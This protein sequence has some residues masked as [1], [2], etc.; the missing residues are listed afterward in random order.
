MTTSLRRAL[1][2]NTNRRESLD[3]AENESSDLAPRSSRV[4]RKG[5]VKRLLSVFGGF[6]RGA[7]DQSQQIQQSD[8]LILKKSGL[9]EL[10]SPVDSPKIGAVRKQQVDGDE[11]RMSIDD[12]HPVR[13]MRLGVS[14]STSTDLSQM[15]TH[16]SGDFLPDVRSLKRTFHESVDEEVCYA[17]HASYVDTVGLLREADVAR[18]ILELEGKM[19]AVGEQVRECLVSALKVD[20]L[21]RQIHQ[22]V[23]SATKHEMDTQSRLAGLVELVRVG[24]GGGRGGLA[25]QLAELDGRVKSLTRQLSSLEDDW[26]QAA[27][28]REL[29]RAREARVE[30][31]RVGK[32]VVAF[33]ARH[34]LPVVISACVSSLASARRAR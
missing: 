32:V 33:V 20:H 10:D 5:T 34:V 4:A 16:D 11:G 30:R 7:S 1:S 3:S 9:L 18:R 21:G 28:E 15:T 6:E 22:V 2:L 12:L 25:E 13:A 24:G 31:A 14:T 17:S 19:V 26:E 8:E 23:A 29:E 27:G